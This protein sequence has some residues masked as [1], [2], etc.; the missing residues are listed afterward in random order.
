MSFDSPGYPLKFIQRDRCKDET[1]H[2]F[3]YIYKFCSPRTKLQY[4]IRADF[5]EEDV[6]SIKFYVQQHSKSDYKYSKV[7]NK[8]DVGNILASCVKVIP[9]LLQQ[10]PKASFGLI[11]GRTIDKK[12]NKAESYEENQRF[13]IYRKYASQKIGSKTFTHVEYSSISAY[14]LINNVNT[15]IEEKEG[16]IKKMF[17]KTYPDL[18]NIM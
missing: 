12:A 11:G 10:Y 5:H 17:I 14:L 7:T 4:I 16:L 13:R 6:F 2:Q 15:N 3:T 9:H 8:G 1:S 18:L